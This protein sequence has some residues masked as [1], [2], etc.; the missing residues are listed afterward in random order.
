MR[1]IGTAGYKGPLHYHKIRSRHDGSNP[2]IEEAAQIEFE[3]RQRKSDQLS[4]TLQYTR[5]A[6]GK[7]IK[8]IYE[9]PL[10][11]R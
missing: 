3:S 1:K 6:T 8:T 2:K 10:P 7:A 5:Q 9:H 4:N 11:L